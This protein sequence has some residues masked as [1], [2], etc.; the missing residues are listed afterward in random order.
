MRRSLGLDA[1]ERRERAAEHVVEAAVLVRA[2][3]RDEVGAAARRRRST[4]AVAAGVAAD[5]ARSPPR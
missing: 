4:R 1:V 3:E 2:L 5:L